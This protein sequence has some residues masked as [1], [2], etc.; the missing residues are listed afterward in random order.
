MPFRVHYQIFDNQH[1]APDFQTY[2]YTMARI[3]WNARMYNNKGLLWHLEQT[4]IPDGALSKQEEYLMLVYRVRKLWRQ[5]FDCGRKK[6]DLMASVEQEKKLDDWNK[7]T[8]AYVESHPG[9]KP[10]NKKS[11]SFYIVVSAW[12]DTWKERKRY[13]GSAACDKDVLAEISKKCRQF[14]K[15]I[16]KYIKEQLKLI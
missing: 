8:K 14:E 9:Y 5:Y 13:T 2:D 4:V 16:D 7:R 3:E 1:S 11:Y 12:R 6:E 10:D 15:E